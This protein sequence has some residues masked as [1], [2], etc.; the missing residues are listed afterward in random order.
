M[1]DNIDL[2]DSLYLV[3]RSITDFLKDKLQEKRGFKHSI[4]TI[5]TLK[6]WK[7]EINAWEFQNIYIRSDAITVT[8]QRFKLND[9]F[10]KILN[11][12]DSWEGEG[13]GWVIDQVQDIHIN[14]NNYDPFAVSSYIPTLPELNNSKQGII[15]R[16]RFRMNL[17]SIFA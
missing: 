9:V 1:I 8:N 4:L 11:L 17:H 16:T 5:V 13:S 14:I 2:R 15:P 3:K 10:T 12:L 7:A 6:K